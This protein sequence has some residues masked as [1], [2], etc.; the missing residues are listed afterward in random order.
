MA[1]LTDAMK[2]DLHIGNSQLAILAYNPTGSTYTTP[3]DFSSA[4]VLFTLEGTLNFDE[5]AP[6]NNPIRLDQKHEVID[7]EFTDDQEYTMTGDIPS[8]NLALMSYFFEEGS[9][10]TGV[11]G[12][13]ADFTYA[14]KGYG[15]A[16]TKDVV[17]LAVSQ[18][19]KTAIILNH[20][21]M[22]LSHPKGSDNT[23]PKIMSITGLCIA[24]VNG[25]VVTPLPTAT[26]VTS[27]SED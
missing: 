25:I 24:D 12:P 20:V 23:S 17:V 21:K 26:A 8:I 2:Q 18:S 9:A 22:R 13:D 16:K 7:N 11:K 4:D 19:K 14:G 5:G 15:A 27:G 10:V 1:T 3:T 6:S